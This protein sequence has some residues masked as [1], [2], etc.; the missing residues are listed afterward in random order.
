MTAAMQDK[1]PPYWEQDHNV[2]IRLLTGQA[3]YEGGC[4]AVP[5]YHHLLSN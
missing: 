5:W 3:M 2:M 4:I 1:H